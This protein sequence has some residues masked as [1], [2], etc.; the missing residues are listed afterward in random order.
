MN[1]TELSVEQLKALAYDQIVLSNQ[2]QRNIAAIEAEL[3][4]RQQ[5]DTPQQEP[6]EPGKE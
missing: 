4:K 2:A 1:I 6:P 5:V 3:A